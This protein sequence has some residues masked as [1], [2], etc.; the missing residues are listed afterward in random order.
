MSKSHTRLLLALALTAAGVAPAMA[1]MNGT[2]SMSRMERPRA[3]QSNSQQSQWVSARVKSANVA[4]RK[5]TVAH[6][7]IKSIGMPPMT[8]TFA[9]ADATQLA[10]LKKGDRVEIQVAD[11]EGAATIVNFR[12]QR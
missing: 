2:E 12:T 1:G 5:I 9:V 3:V 7:A 8:M 6:A 11:L 4:A 10:S